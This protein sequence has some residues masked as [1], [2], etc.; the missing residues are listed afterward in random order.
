MELPGL[1]WTEVGW[2]LDF[3][4]ISTVIVEQRGRVVKWMSVAQELY[5]VL[6]IVVLLL[7][8]WQVWLAE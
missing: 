4:Q 3:E 1:L 7:A 6:G 5:F 8:V 2:M